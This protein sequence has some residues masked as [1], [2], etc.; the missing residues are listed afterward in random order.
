DLVV[1]FRHIEPSAQLIETIR[2]RGKRL[3][4]GRVRCHCPNPCPR[5]PANQSS[6]VRNAQENRAGTFAIPHSGPGPSVLESGGVH[7]APKLQQALRFKTWSAAAPRQ[8][9]STRPSIRCCR[10]A[11]FIPQKPTK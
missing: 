7:S 3:P 11:V 4:V 10:K 8:S 1:G 6:S 9:L 2:Q 5:E